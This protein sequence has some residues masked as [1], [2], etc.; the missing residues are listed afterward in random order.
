MDAAPVARLTIE[1]DGIDHALVTELVDRYG[2]LVKFNTFI[3]VLDASLADLPDQ[4]P[5][6]PGDIVIPTAGTRSD[7]AM[8]AAWE[9]AVLELDD[10]LECLYVDHGDDQR[11]VVVWPFGY[12]AAGTP[13]TV[14]NAA[15]EPVATV[16]EATNLGGGFVSADD[17][18]T[19]QHCGADGA[20]FTSGPTMFGLQQR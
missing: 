4:T 16:G 8:A 19:A 10:G 20:F 1:G 6:V 18:D 3:T 17:V 13:K 14:Y 15:G 9:G 2:D 7:A 11:T 5:A 12:T